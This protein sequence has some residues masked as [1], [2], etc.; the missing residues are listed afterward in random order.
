MAMHL[1]SPT[2]INPMRSSLL[3]GKKAHARASCHAIS[4][5]SPENWSVETCTYH[6]EGSENPI[7]EQA[8]ADLLPHAPVGENFMQ[9]LVAHFA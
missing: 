9:G 4:M 2:S 6:E 1:P 3:S 5:W 8:E 7:D